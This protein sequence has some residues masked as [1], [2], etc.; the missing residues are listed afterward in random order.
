MTA[1]DFAKEP[2]E[3]LKTRAKEEGVSVDARV[4][5]VFSLPETLKNTQD[6]ILEYTCFCAID[7]SRR[8][9]YVEALSSTLRK[10]GHL[11]ALVFPIWDRKEGPPYAVCPDQWEET[12]KRHGLQV[13]QRGPSEDSHPAR[14]AHETLIIFQKE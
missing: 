3:H 6:V 10:G 11:L 4:L 7:P 2:I 12:A 8:D 14:A 9:E 1:I 5:D 13:Q